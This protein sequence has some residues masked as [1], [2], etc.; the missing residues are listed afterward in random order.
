[1]DTHG[2][3]LAGGR[4]REQWEDRGA[5]VGSPGGEGQSAIPEAVDPVC[6][7]RVAIPG[8]RHIHEHADQRYYFCCPSCR[9]LFVANPAQYLD[10]GDE[11]PKQ[12]VP[13]DAISG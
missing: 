1:M 10:G 3:P 4:A 2:F 5:M 8:A 7:M 12:G 9:R 6:G 13:S 11:S